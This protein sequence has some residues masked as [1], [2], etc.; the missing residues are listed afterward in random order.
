MLV[1]T[2]DGVTR[3]HGCW[4]SD[5]DIMN[6]IDEYTGTINLINKSRAA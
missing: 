1:K 2:T 4:M 6:F 3:L 5:N